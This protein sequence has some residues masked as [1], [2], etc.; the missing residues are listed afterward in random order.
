M[1][2]LCFSLLEHSESPG[3]FAGRRFLTAMI[4]PFEPQ[5]GLHVFE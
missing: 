2:T 1:R 4:K 5:I 3:I